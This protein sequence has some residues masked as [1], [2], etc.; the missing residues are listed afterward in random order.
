MTKILKIV[1][2]AVVLLAIPVSV[3]IISRSGPT[4]YLVKAGKSEDV[5]VFLMPAVVSLSPGEK[6]SVLVKI[7]TGSVTIGGVDLKINYNPSVLTL[8]ETMTTGLTFSYLTSETGKGM[9]SLVGT[10]EVLGQGTMAVLSF[11][12]FSSGESQLEIDPGSVV[13]DQTL[14][15]NIFG[16]SVGAKITVK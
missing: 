9:V 8:A 13:W 1:L 15:N 3:F 11:E 4:G 16:K 2:L 7:D 10:G 5:L 6:I 14:K 12:A